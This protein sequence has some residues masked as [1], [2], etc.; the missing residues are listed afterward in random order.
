M[1]L[2]LI[3]YPVLMFV[4]IGVSLAKD[5]WIEADEEGE[6]G[7]KKG[8]CVIVLTLIFVWMLE[9]L[10]ACQQAVVL[11]PVISMT[12]TPFC[13]I[14]NVPSNR[15]YGACI[16]KWASAGLPYGIP[17]MILGGG[18]VAVAYFYF[19][20]V[21]WKKAE[22]GS[23][24]SGRCLG[25]RVKEEDRGGFFTDD[26]FWKNSADTCCGLTG[27]AAGSTA[28]FGALLF[29]IWLFGGLTIGIWFEASE[30]AIFGDLGVFKMILAPSAPICIRLLEFLSM[31]KITGKSRR[32]MEGTSGQ[33]TTENIGMGS[34]YDTGTGDSD[35]E[36]TNT[37]LEENN[38]PPY[39]LLPH[40]WASAVDHDTRR[41]Y[42]INRFEHSTS[43][44]HPGS[45]GGAGYDNDDYMLP[46]MSTAG[47]NTH[48]HT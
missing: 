32:V 47:K 43:W 46:G 22:I 36:M 15:K 31:F 11:L 45:S 19:K 37:S 17:M 40:G 25:I 5:M 12:Y 26:H 13:A 35:I 6:G 28:F 7:E 33:S 41:R 42:Y 18:G 34:N 8:K 23:D 48:T 44:N 21:Q 2:G 39:A 24:R 1:V 9:V 16:H 27:L 38:Q 4:S 20:K 30:W 29:L 14:M 3:I 10:L